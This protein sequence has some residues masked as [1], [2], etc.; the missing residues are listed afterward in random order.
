MYSP[1]FESPRNKP[2][3][4]RPEIIVG[5]LVMMTV[6]TVPNVSYGQFEI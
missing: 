3:E 5:T 1:E 4:L 6:V 2:L